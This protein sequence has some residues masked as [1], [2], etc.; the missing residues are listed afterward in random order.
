VLGVERSLGRARAGVVLVLCLLNAACSRYQTDEP[1]PVERAPIVQPAPVPLGPRPLVG[2]HYYH[3]Y[4]GNWAVG[5][6]RGA[7]DPP[8]PPELGWYDSTDVSVAEQHIAWASEHGIDFFTLDSW[9]VHH[10]ENQAAIARFLEAPN[11]ADI[12]F[13]I[14]YE[15]WDLSFDPTRGYADLD[16][17]GARAAFVEDMAQL[18]DQYFD[19]PS[20]LRIDGRPVVILYLTRVLVGDVAGAMA[21]VR[22]M[23]RARGYDPYVV[24]DEIFW[25]VTRSG[26]PPAF[27]SEPQPDRIRLF[28]A[29]TAYNPYESSE[30]SH[31]GYSASSQL[32]PD[33]V[34]LYQRYSDATSGD[35]P[36]VPDV[37]PGY[38][39]R[40]VRPSLDHY[41]IPRARAPDAADG[42]LLA[43][44]LDRVAD[45]WL[46]ARAP[47]VMVTSWNEWNE[48]SAIE[49]LAVAEPTSADTAGDGIS[50]TQG[51][52]YEG[53]GT[54][55]L[56]ILRDHYVAVAGR[57]TRPDGAPMVGLRVTASRDG[58]LLAEDTTDHAGHYTLARAHLG[59]GSVVVTVGR[60]APRPVTIDP[61]RTSAVDV[62]VG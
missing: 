10:Q 57:V 39:D 52:R 9:P 31:A 28:D 30:I 7:L 41:A 27:T 42:T 40:G 20:Y 51:Y 56:E 55:Y 59:A 43:D 6:L 2:A 58:V 47:M 33:V 11:I 24:G 53:F 36:I 3:W 23:W 18:A 45:P 34:G 35:V 60:E 22:A 15:T 8:Q 16:A 14:F 26:G 19:H 50:R 13:T 49:P 48:D 61:E 62:E 4:P 44:M 32:L 17:P 37:L 1:R 29:I 38:N 46:D 12:A 21:E 5:T 54:R 25:R